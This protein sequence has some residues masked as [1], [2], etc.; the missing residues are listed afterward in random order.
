MSLEKLLENLYVDEAC[1][2]YEDLNDNHKIKIAIEVLKD[3]ESYDWYEI[4][5]YDENINIVS[6]LESSIKEGLSNYD[7]IK[8]LS[9]MISSSIKNEINQFFCEMTDSILRSGFDG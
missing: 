4:F 6:L 9:D 7:T 3:I 5:F 1:M 2:K 8:G